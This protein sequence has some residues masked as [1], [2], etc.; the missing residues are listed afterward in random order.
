M[1]TIIKRLLDA[2][3]ELKEV[4][5]NFQHSIAVTFPNLIKEDICLTEAQLEN[6]LEYFLSSALIIKSGRIKIPAALMYH[7]ELNLTRNPG[8]KGA[9]ESYRTIHL[10]QVRAIKENRDL[11]CKNTYNDNSVIV[12]LSI[13][14]DHKHIDQTKLDIFYDLL[15]KGL[16]W[17]KIWE[18]YEK[19]ETG[20]HKVEDGGIILMDKGF[21]IGLKTNPES[22]Y[23]TELTTKEIEEFKSAF[24][25][26]DPDLGF[27][28]KFLEDYDLFEKVLNRLEKEKEEILR[29]GSVLLEEFKEANKSFRVLQQLKNI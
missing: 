16:H 13:L 20:I 23:L 18:N 25:R 27:L 14:K 12:E 6:E 21:K 11:E 15:R 29:K 10:L 8:L 28:I 9:Y 22:A 3:K 1:K 26:D 2:K 5:D 17:K 4:Q 7:K 19:K 24:R